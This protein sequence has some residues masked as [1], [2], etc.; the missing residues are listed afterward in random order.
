MGIKPANGP[1]RESPD[2]RVPSTPRAGSRSLRI[3]IFLALAIIVADQTTKAFMLFAIMSPPRVLSV[4]PFFNLRLGFNTGISF[5]LFSSNSQFVS[6]ALSAIAIVI[7]LGLIGLLYRS[8]HMG[9]II[10]LGAAIGGALGNVIDRV[11]QGAVTDFLDFHVGDWHWPT[12]NLADT[13]ITVGLVLFVISP[14]FS[15]MPSAR[16]GGSS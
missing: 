15:R 14:V 1:Q 13:A 7:V 4:T 11:R 12:F 2:S 6:W 16:L 9:E 8:R 10:G 5:G 3:G